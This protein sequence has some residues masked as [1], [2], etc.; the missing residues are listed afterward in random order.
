M[1]NTISEETSA[2]GRIIDSKCGN[3]NACVDICPVQAFTG[4]EFKEEE[5]REIRYDARKC[6]RYINS[7]GEGEKIK[8]CGMCLYVC[9][10]GQKNRH[11][12]N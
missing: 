1:K 3:C 7:L 11:L 10:Y 4:H 9:P 12:Q 5:P 2:E 6:E 8:V